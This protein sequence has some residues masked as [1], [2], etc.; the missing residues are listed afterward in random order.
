M[1]RLKHIVC[2]SG[3]HS[4]A[5][6]AIEVVKL[7]GK[8]NVILLNHNINPRYEDADIKRFKK[9]VAD[10][11]GLPITFANIKGIENENDIPNQFEVCEEKKTFVNPH[12]RQILCTFALPLRLG[13]D[14]RNYV[15][16][17]A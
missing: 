4:S 7:F 1:S 10:Y 9:E 15:L 16:W 6:V 3:G 8:E 11:L 17:V 2:Y 12:N 5:L 13:S 14:E